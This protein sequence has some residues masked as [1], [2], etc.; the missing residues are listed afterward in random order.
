MRTISTSLERTLDINSSSTSKAPR[1][2]FIL[3][4]EVLEQTGRESQIAR[5]YV[6]SSSGMSID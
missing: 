5:V 4:I 6:S 1:N 3:P 2:D